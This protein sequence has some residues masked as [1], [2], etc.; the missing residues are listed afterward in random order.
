CRSG[1]PSHASRR[2]GSRRR[3]HAAR[4]LVPADSPG[5]PPSD[6]RFPGQGVRHLYLPA[7]HKCRTPSGIVALATRRVAGA[8][9]LSR[10]RSVSVPPEGK[11]IHS[12][13]RRLGPR[14]SCSS[15]QKSPLDRK[16]PWAKAACSKALSPKQPWAFHS[17]CAAPPFS[18]RRSLVTKRCTRGTCFIITGRCARRRPS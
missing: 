11:G 9:G 12:T 15:L 5:H 10:R 7:E 6:E 1:Q 18:A 2:H 17:F 8:A 13:A 3:G 16:V 14:S 4:R